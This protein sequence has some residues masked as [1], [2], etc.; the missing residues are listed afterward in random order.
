MLTITV[1]QDGSGDFASVSEAV[2]AVPYACAAEIRIGPG[3]YR[4]KLVC[5]KQDITLIGAGM[6]SS[7][8]AALSDLLPHRG[9][10]A[11]AI[12]QGSVLLFTGNAFE[13]LGS[14]ITDASG[15]EYPALGF[16]KFTVQETDARIT[17]DVI[18]QCAQIKEPVVGFVNKCTLI[19]GIEAP[20]FTVSMGPGNQAGDPREGL[21][22]GNVFG[23]HLT[24]PILVKN[25]SFLDYIT[26]LLGKR[27]QP[28]FEL[29]PMD[30][31]HPLRAYEITLQELTKRRDGV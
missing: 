31:P 6:E 13:L 14:S 12:G 22:L 28:Q 21:C 7:Q 27:Q 11:S 1:A 10:L 23:T 17:G 18:C 20:L 16:S 2:L 3:V 9:E 5:E 15:R 30:N 25:P 26:D 8:K 19:K 4:E 29:S 24:G